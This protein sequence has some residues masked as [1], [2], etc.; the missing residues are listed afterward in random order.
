MAKALAWNFEGEFITK[1]KSFTR[2][3]GG[4]KIGERIRGNFT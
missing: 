3:P 2:E 4:T 1:E